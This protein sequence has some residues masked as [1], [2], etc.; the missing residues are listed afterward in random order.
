MGTKFIP[1]QKFQLRPAHSNCKALVTEG[2]HV[3]SPHLERA[4]NIGVSHSNDVF[5]LFE[6]R[7]QSTTKEQ[8][9]KELAEFL[10][11]IENWVIHFDG[12]ANTSDSTILCIS[13]G[14][15]YADSD[16]KS[17]S[18]VET[19]KKVVV[20]SLALAGLVPLVGVGIIVGSIPA[21]IASGVWYYKKHKG[22]PYYYFRIS[23]GPIVNEGE[24][25]KAMW[26]RDTEN[27]ETIK[28]GVLAEQMYQHYSR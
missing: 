11:K 13:M 16:L 1:S 26:Y 15:V 25:C 24:D 12:S 27:V 8:S 9:K 6:V 7:Y 10:R 28:L 20:A 23:V 19:G 2:H 22:N 3:I 18:S 4:I 14:K 17:Y 21:A 5:E